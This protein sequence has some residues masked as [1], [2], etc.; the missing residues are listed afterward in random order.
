[1]EVVVATLL[2]GQGRWSQA[3]PR[4]TVGPLTLAPSEAADFTV[5]SGFVA[6]RVARTRPV[7]EYQPIPRI[8]GVGKA[9]FT[10]IVGRDGRVKDVSV[11]QMLRNGNNAALLGAIQSWRFRRATENGEPVAAPYSVEISFKRE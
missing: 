6:N 9:R 8:S 7:P 3:G 4:I 1:M 10:M 5:T 2:R 11:Q